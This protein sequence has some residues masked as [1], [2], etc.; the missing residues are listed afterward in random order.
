M[1]NSIIAI[2][3]VCILCGIFLTSCGNNEIKPDYLLEGAMDNGFVPAYRA[4]F[5]IK[6]NEVAEISKTK[7][8]NYI[9]RDNNHYE[10]VPESYYL[11]EVNAETK[12][13]LDWEYE[14]NK[15]NDGMYDTEILKNQLLDMN[16]SFE[17]SVDIQI[18][19]FDEYI[20]IE[21]ANMNDAN[22]VMDSKYA[23]F[24]EGKMLAIADDINLSSIRK[25]YRL[26]E[27][28]K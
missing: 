15:Y 4:Y 18:T 20:L 23:I 2:I 6:N 21:V 5:A 26:K 1:K 25:I 28:G 24:H 9:Y 7:Y 22:T 17:G 19:E 13:P 12:N 11:F 27:K 16:V 10:I 14:Q 8:E 3:S